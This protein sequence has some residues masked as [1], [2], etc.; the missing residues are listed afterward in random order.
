MRTQL[1][2]LPGERGAKQL[3]EQYEDQLVCVRY[4]HAEQQ[5]KRFKTVEFIIKEY[6]WRSPEKRQPLDRLIQI[7]VAVSEREVR[8]QVKEAYGIH[9]YGCG[10]SFITRWFLSG[11]KV[12]S[13]KVRVYKCI[14]L[15]S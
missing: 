8:Q 6:D 1:T 15:A 5:Q 14:A 4:R 11:W 10:R 12:A 2:L 9:R 3:R 7:R 13:S